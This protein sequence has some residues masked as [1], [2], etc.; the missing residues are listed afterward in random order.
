M[1]KIKGS[2]VVALKKLFSKS[3]GDVES[4]FLSTLSED[5]AKAYKT[6]V[7]TTWTE[8]EV[9]ARLYEAAGKTLFPGDP[10]AVVKLH[11]KLA[12][13]S[14]SGI[15]S[16]FLAIPKASF[17]FKRAAS[18]W[19]TYYDKGVAS[20]ENITDSSMDFVVR[21]FPELP[22]ALRDATTGHISVLLGKTGLKNLQVRHASTNPQQWV[23]NTTWK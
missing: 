18:V 4:K 21:G 16:A 11:Q 1:P 7:A 15:Y 23:W 20:I 19:T 6:I 9:Q 14:Y 17:V 12:E 2:D 8:V 13:Q 5:D 3:G 10:N 22:K